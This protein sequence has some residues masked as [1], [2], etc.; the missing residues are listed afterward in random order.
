M[1]W[2]TARKKAA[3]KG[4]QMEPQ[5][6]SNV[7]WINNYILSYSSFTPSL[8][9]A[10]L[11]ACLNAERFQISPCGNQHQRMESN[12]N[13]KKSNL[14]NP[15]RQRQTEGNSKWGAGLWAWQDGWEGLSMAWSKC[16]DTRLHILLLLLLL[17]VM[18]PMMML[19]DMWQVVKIFC[20]IQFPSLWSLAPLCTLCLGYFNS[21]SASHGMLFKLPRRTSHWII[22]VSLLS[23]F[24]A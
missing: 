12:N 22:T 8:P 24:L 13:K 14:E 18:V 7:H 15:W 21:A 6:L 23:A 20:R 3:K 10:C 4:L 11:V 5:R 2:R 16:P 9:C 1:K 19:V 17:L